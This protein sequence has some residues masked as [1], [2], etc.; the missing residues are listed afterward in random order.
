NSEKC[1][2]FAVLRPPEEGGSSREGQH[3]RGVRRAPEP[4][5]FRR[6]TTYLKDPPG[7]F[8]CQEKTVSLKKEPR[9]SLGITIAGGRDCRSRL[10]VYITSVQPVG[11][12][13]RDGT[14][15]RGTKLHL[16][17]HKDS[18]LGFLSVYIIKCWPNSK[19]TGDNEWVLLANQMETRGLINCCQE[20]KCKESQ[21]VCLQQYSNQFHN[22]GCSTV[23]NIV[24]HMLHIII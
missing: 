4:Q 19:C 8:F 3:S 2:N 6:Q 18:F 13:H 20:P 24:V 16:H 23:F 7:G 11:C 15:K 5:Y 1:V 17:F 9:T 12:L 10:P 21:L 22:G 14:I